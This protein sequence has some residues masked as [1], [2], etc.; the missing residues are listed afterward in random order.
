MGQYRRNYVQGGIFFFTVVTYLRQPLLNDLTIPMLQEGFKKC[1]SRKVFSVEAMVILPDHLH[2]I[3]QLP[4]DD[5]DYSS[6]WKFIKAFFTK[7][8]TKRWVTP[9][10]THPTG[11]TEFLSS[12][13]SYN[14]SRKPCRV[15]EATAQPTNSEP[16]NPKPTASMQKKGEKG[17]WQRRFWEHTIRDERDYRTHCDYIHYNPVKHGLVN[18]PRDWPHSS[19]H[20]FVEK[21]L[22][23]ESWGGAVNA[24]SD[25]VG[26]NDGCDHPLIIWW[27]A[28]RS[29]HP[30]GTED[31]KNLKPVRILRV[32]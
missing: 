28:L 16:P 4:P 7:E 15:G 13:G 1:I 17:I 23:A 11:K 5:D 18:S 10:C 31:N 26:V 27:V 12:V 21:G 20:K 19:F 3:W 6:R 32:A 2:C 9:C 30:T 29:T 25:E 8:Y 14:N 24:F 22:Y